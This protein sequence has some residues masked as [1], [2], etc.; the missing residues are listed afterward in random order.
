MVPCFGKMR[1]LV[2][3]AKSLPTSA[4]VCRVHEACGLASWVGG[5]LPC[6]MSWRPWSQVGVRRLSKKRKNK[7]QIQI[8]FFIFLASAKRDVSSMHHVMAAM[9]S[10]WGPS[11]LEKKEKTKT[12]FKIFFSFFC[13]CLGLAMEMRAF[14]EWRKS[15]G[16]NW[17]KC[18]FRRRGRVNAG[19]CS[20]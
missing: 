12:K 16:A 5:S 20:S 15:F 18:C 6:I 13:K 7:N 17:V 14:S 9:V 11:T 2:Q 8:L 3:S 4:Y 1:V 10:S 19:W